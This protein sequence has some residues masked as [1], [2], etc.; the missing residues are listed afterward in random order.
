MKVYVV[1]ENDENLGVYV[2][3]VYSSSEEADRV[4]GEEA[5]EDDRWVIARE[6]NEN[7]WK[8]VLTYF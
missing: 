8:K 5:H 4:A 6:L 2:V 7:N 1:L 3:G